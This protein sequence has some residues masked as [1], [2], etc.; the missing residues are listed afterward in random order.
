MT[1]ALTRDQLTVLRLTALG[2]THQK[3]A[4]RLGTTPASVR[5]HSR[6]MQAALGARNAPHAVLLGVRSGLVEAGGATCRH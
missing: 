2:Y 6:R 4:V 5:N 3:M 1:I